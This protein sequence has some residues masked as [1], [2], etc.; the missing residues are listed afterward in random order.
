MEV[1]KIFKNKFFVDFLGIAIVIL[2]FSY[3]MGKILEV[4]LPKKNK[5]TV[6]KPTEIQ[7][8]ERAI[9]YYAPIVEQ[10]PFG[11]R[12]VKFSVIEKSEQKV[13][14]FDAQSL[15]LKG[16]ITLS[17]GYAFIENKDRVQ[18]L[19]KR[20]ED[21]FGYGILA[22]VEPKS[23]TISQG[24]KMVKIVLEGVVEEGKQINGP[25]NQPALSSSQNEKNFA[26]EEIKRF[27]NNPQEILTDARLLPNLKDGKQEGFVVREVRPGGFYERMGIQN[28]DIILRANNVEL[29]SPNDGIKIFN[30]IR[31]IDRVELDILRDGK[32]IKLIYNIN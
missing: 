3:Q 12:G 26:R 20:G 10:N 5:N 28:G 11:I 13:V 27:I 22:L 4:A 16:T 18:K 21:V 25:P 14:S 32:P 6:F 31:E 8:G 29:A 7:R 24:G 23:V 9:S 19:F 2:A 17:P 30:L 15:K 1:V